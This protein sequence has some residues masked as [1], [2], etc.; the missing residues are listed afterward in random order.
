V[1]RSLSPAG[2]IYQGSR[3]LHRVGGENGRGTQLRG[4]PARA[5]NA[6]ISSPT[7]SGRMPG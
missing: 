5:S 3:I 6:C 1:L 4:R 7:W 2:L